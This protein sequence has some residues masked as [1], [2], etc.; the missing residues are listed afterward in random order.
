MFSSVVG[1]RRVM[2]LIASVYRTNQYLIDPYT[3]ISYG[4]LQDY[5][6][7]TG[8]NKLTV[9]F[10]EGNPEHFADVIS[11]ATGLPVRDIKK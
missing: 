11:Q 6:A 2:D 1:G 3:A 9:L 7:K 4:T 10:S 8:E 5:R